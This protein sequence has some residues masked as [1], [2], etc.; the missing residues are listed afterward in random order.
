M[1]QIHRCFKSI[2]KCIFKVFYF[3]HK[4]LLAKLIFN[5]SRVDVDKGRFVKL[6]INHEITQLIGEDGSCSTTLDNYDGC[7]YDLLFNMT[8]QE[9]GCT[10]PWLPGER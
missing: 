6:A 8:M 3:F 2:I 4:T 10:I 7:I 1:R 5:R 9:V